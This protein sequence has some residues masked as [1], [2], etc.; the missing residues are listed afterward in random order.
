LVRLREIKKAYVIFMKKSPG[1]IIPGS[2]TSSWDDNIN[3]DVRE[4]GYG[5]GGG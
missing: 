4:I 2:L 5:V 1:H 3:V